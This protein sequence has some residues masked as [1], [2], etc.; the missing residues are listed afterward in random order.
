MNSANHAVEITNTMS[1]VPVTGSFFD[2][3]ATN[4]LM[5]IASIAILGLAALGIWR[6]KRTHA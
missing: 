2:N 6:Y 4:V 5:V 1:D 3:N